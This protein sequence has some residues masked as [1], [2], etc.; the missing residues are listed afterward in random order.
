MSCTGLHSPSILEFSTGTELKYSCIVMNTQVPGISGKQGTIS[1]REIM[2]S[3]VGKE[4][5]ASIQFQNYLFFMFADNIVLTT[6]TVSLFIIMVAVSFKIFHLQKTLAGLFDY[7]DKDK[8]LIPPLSYKQAIPPIV[9]KKVS[10]KKLKIHNDE[11]Y[12]PTTT[13]LPLSEDVR[14]K[15]V[16][17][18][19]EGES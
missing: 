9:K 8:E 5:S 14:M 4:K 2:S 10:I 15:S 1:G 18:M 12:R 7:I 3:N 11:V 19:Q 16:N 13:T 6:L 17:D